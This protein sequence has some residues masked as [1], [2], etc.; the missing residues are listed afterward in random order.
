M[1]RQKITLNIEDCI[2]FAD[3]PN[4]NGYK[5]NKNGVVIS[6]ICRGEYRPAPMVVLSRVDFTGYPCVMLNNKPIRVHR[7]LATCFIANPNNYPWIDHIDRNK[8][9]NDLSNLRWANASMNNTNK[10]KWYK[11]DAKYIYINSFTDKSG[12]YFKYYVVQ[13]LNKDRVYIRKRFLSEQ[14]AI[15]FVNLCKANDNR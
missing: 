14:E 13:Y 1:T 2:D 7:L 8:T 4:F 10:G 9:N 12:K 3:I 11:K 5:I 6:T 15:N